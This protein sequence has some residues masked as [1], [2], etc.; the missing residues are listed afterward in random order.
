MDKL[1]VKQTEFHV[2][3]P[4]CSVENSCLIV[5]LPSLVKEEIMFFSVV[6]LRLSKTLDLKY[7]HRPRL[8]V[9][10]QCLYVA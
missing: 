9:S 8:A 4:A 1:P 3:P 5:S 2:A 10:T 7:L 6:P